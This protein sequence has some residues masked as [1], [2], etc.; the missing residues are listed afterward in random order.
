MNYLYGTNLRSSYY[1]LKSTFA[2]IDS[3]NEDTEGS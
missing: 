2:N 1:I 3:V